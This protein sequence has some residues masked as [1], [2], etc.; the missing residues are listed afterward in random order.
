MI[1][2]D[3][4]TKRFPDGT[5]AV[6]N[7]DLDI[8]DGQITVLV[9]TSGCGKTTTLRMINRM[10]EPVRADAGGTAVDGLARR[11]LPYRLPGAGGAPGRGVG[12]VDLDPATGHAPYVQ[13]G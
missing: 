2:F 10:V 7:L 6:A 9:G 1:R 5:T 8:P 13:G 3:D 12:D 4:V 11:H